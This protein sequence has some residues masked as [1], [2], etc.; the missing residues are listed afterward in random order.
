M[1]EFLDDLADVELSPEETREVLRRLAVEEFGGTANTRIRDIAELSSVGPEAI[2]RIV[3]ELRGNA[4]WRNDVD[5]RL[6]KQNEVIEDLKLRSVKIA[7]RIESITEAPRQAHQG[8]PLTYRRLSWPE[9]LHVSKVLLG[10]LIGLI[11]IFW[12]ASAF[13]LR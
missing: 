3:A 12:L 11:L 7:D 2:A 4:G 8:E 13:G 9:K 6:R 1:N 10:M 5:A